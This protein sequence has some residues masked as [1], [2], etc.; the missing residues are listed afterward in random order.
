MII[1][2]IQNEGLLKTDWIQSR[3]RVSQWFGMNKAMYEPFGMKGHNGVDLAFQK[4]LLFM[5][6]WTARQ[7]LKRTRVAMDYMFGLEIH[8]RN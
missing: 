8:I 1:S 6:L 7:L 2:P 3:P 4:E 5:H